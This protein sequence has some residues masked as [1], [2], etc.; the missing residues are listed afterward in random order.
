MKQRPVHPWRSKADFDRRFAKA[1][2]WSLGR[3]DP[4][5]TMG[6]QLAYRAFRGHVIGT[7]S[8]KPRVLELGCG[9]GYFTRFIKD[10]CELCVNDLS[11]VALAR[12]DTP[13]KV[14]GDALDLV[15][16]KVFISTFDCIFALE[17]L[18]YLRPEE[19]VA[20]LGALASNMA[21]RRWFIASIPISNDDIYFRAGEFEDLVQE[22]GLELVE[23]RPGNT[24]WLGSWRNI[25]TQR[26]TRA[27]ARLPF[28]VKA[29]LLRPS[30]VTGHQ[31]L[32]VLRSA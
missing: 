5:T 19:R 12:V 24:M 30:S 9:E 18:H 23:R 16:D 27:A 29:F 11:T 20:F 17:M 26:W 8:A 25:I 7:A 4:E 28:G 22:A 14:P 3:N 10:E 21:S 1:D 13:N 6:Y 31:C 2:P 15:K 32:F